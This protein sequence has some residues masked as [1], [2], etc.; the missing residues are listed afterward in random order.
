MEK[1]YFEALSS[2]SPKPTLKNVVALR[3]CS[4]VSAAWFNRWAP[5]QNLVDG[6][7]LDLLCRIHA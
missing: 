5:R 4:Y 7:K 2:Q 1:M 6:L 3:G